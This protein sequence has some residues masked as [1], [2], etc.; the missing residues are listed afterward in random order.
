MMAEDMDVMYEVQEEKVDEMDC[1]EP[2]KVYEVVPMMAE[3]MGRMDEVI[4][5]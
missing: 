2:Y 5:G 3:D 4:P 1:M